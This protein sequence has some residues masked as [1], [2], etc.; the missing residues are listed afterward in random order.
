MA[1]GDHRNGGV[2][3]ALGGR[4][5]VLHERSR[6]TPRRGP[7]R[8]SRRVSWTPPRAAE[9]LTSW[10]TPH[11]HWLVYTNEYFCTL[12]ARPTAKSSA[13]PFG[14]F[15]LGFPYSGDPHPC[16]C[17]AHEIRRRPGAG[18]DLHCSKRKHNR[19]AKRRVFVHILIYIY[20]YIYITAVGQ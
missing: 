17:T 19:K 18:A 9:R 11:A 3:G 20:I 12:C 6:V 2:P 14:Y 16:T 1:R 4:V 5:N 10:Y 7:K 15:I 8:S 13:R